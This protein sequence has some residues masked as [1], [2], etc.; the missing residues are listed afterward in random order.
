M[1][2]ALL[3]LIWAA[4]VVVNR[5]HLPRW[6]RRAAIARTVG[7]VRFVAA[8]DNQ[9]RPLRLVAAIEIGA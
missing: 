9:A 4:C 2:A 7:A 3:P 6:P 1:I 8:I 5:W